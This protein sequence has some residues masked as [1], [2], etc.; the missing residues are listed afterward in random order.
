MYACITHQ[1]H[2]EWVMHA[3][4]THQARTEWVMHACMTYQARTE[5]LMHACMVYLEPF[6]GEQQSRACF[7]TVT[8]VS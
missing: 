3:C 5:W 8:F 1:A 7:P 6:C 4:M 2:A